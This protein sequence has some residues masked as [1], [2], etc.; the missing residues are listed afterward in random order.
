MSPD[1]LLSWTPAPSATESIVH[2]GPAASQLGSDATAVS[3][4]DANSFRPAGLELGRTYYWR[5]DRS[6][7]TGVNDV[8]AP[9]TWSFTVTDHVTLDDFESYDPWDRL[10]SETW[11]SGGS[12]AAHHGIEYDT[13]RSCEQGMSFYYTSNPAH[14]TKV[15]R[16]FAAPQNWAGIGARTLQLWLHGRTGNAPNGRLYVTVGDGVTQQSCPFPGD[17][18]AVTRPYWQRWDVAL[19]DFHEV[20]LTAIRSITIGFSNVEPG[21]PGLG[22][23]MLYFD[24]LTLAS[25]LCPQDRRPVADVTGDCTVDDRDLER[26]SVDWLDDTARPVPVTPPRQPVAWYRFDGNTN[27]SMGRANGQMSG[28]SGFE[29]GID[30]QAIHFMNKDDAVT[31]PQAATVFAGITDAITITF[32]QYGDDSPHLNDTVCCSNYR[33]GQSNPAIAVH[34]GLWRSPGHYRWDCGSPWS[35]ENRLAG[36]H[37]RKLEWAGRWN[38]WAFTKDIHAGP[39][40]KKGTMIIYLN[41]TLYDRRTGTDSPIENVTSFEIGS[42]WYGHYD[43]LIDDFMIYDYAL[44][45]EEVAY[46]ATWGTGILEEPVPALADFNDDGRIDLHDFT[47]LADQWLQNGQ[48]P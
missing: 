17:P 3:L 25:S 8:T 47:V 9:D 43:G 13:F 21:V 1:A 30:G 29:W 35:F 33:Y 27:D 42:G 20:D 45:P 46:L 12:V 22:S 32:W 26:L 14:D 10:L 36:R 7:A 16:T 37:E 38:H 11:V 41:G 48:W 34:L 6:V 23:G 28:R 18:N 24:D 5:V 15:T 19:D 2:I 39:V 4:Q 44:P 31:I 40:G